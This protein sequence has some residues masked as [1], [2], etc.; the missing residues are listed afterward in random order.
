MTVSVCTLAH[1]RERHLSNLMSGLA[2][3]RRQPMEL[4]VAVMQAIAQEGL[5]VLDTR[6]TGDYVAFRPFELAA[7]LNR[8]RTLRVMDVE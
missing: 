1:G 6:C 5:D 2:R 8:L 3:N 7:A 4:V